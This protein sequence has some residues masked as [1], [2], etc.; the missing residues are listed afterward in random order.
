MKVEGTAVNNYSRTRCRHWDCPKYTRICG[1]PC[2]N[3][4]FV[5]W[6]SVFGWLWLQRRLF[7]ICGQ[8]CVL[9]FHRGFTHGCRAAGM[10]H[11]RV[12]CPPTSLTTLKQEWLMYLP[13][14]LERLHP[15]PSSPR[16][17]WEENTCSPL[18]FRCTAQRRHHEK[19]TRE[20]TD[21]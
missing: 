1:H 15:S 21:T 7:G 17:V 2:L 6:A 4:V 16:S 11:H 3:P 19:Q 20:E 5:S 14:T 18:G 13:A 12:G 9:E 8:D 10:P